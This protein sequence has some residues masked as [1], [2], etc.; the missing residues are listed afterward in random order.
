MDVYELAPALLAVGESFQEANRELNGDQAQI[1]V[2]VRDKFE[3][4]SFDLYLQ[5]DPVVL[6]QAICCQV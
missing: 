2:K 1:S 3:A 4:G 5:I 6:A